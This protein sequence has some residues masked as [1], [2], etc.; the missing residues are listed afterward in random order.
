MLTYASTF[1]GIAGVGNSVKNQNRFR[2]H[3]CTFSATDVYKTFL[4]MCRE[5]KY[6][7]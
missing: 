6:S 7:F 2:D 1:G 3:C 4:I 5:Q